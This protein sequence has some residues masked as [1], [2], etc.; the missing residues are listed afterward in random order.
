MTL[1]MAD[2]GLAADLRN[3]RTCLALLQ[4]ERLCIGRSRSLNPS[5]PSLPA[6]KHEPKTPSSN[7]PVLSGKSNSAV[8]HPG[9]DLDDALSISE[10]VDL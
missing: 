9:I 10:N 3:P 8:R 5:P 7:D 2:L 4:D 1:P 6:R